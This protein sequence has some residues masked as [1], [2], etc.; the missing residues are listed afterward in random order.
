VDTTFRIGITPDFDRTAKGLIDPVLAEWLDGIPGVTHERLA[1]VGSVATPAQLR[2]VDAVIN[3][4]VRFEAESFTGR[5]RLAV[6]A[7]WG[8][9]YEMIDVDACTANDVALCIT[10]EG[11]RRPM[12]EAEMAMVLAL[13]KCLTA[14]DRATRR[15][16]WRG[17][18]V[19]LG[20]CIHN[21]VVGTIGLGNI[22]S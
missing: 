14:K 13:S 22:G 5:D 21:R 17:E 16:T 6:I 11:V 4:A 20:V 18:G 12:A 15:G 3:L 8:V 10:P 19:G 1:E 7:R 2:D 9:G